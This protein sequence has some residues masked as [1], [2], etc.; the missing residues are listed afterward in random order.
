M[1]KKTTLL[2]S[3]TDPEMYQ[4]SKTRRNSF[5]VDKPAFVL[6]DPDFADPFSADWLTAI[7]AAE[8]MPSNETLDDQSIQLTEDVEKE[9]EK[10][11]KKFQDSKYFI[12]KTFPDRPSRWDEFGYDNY[13][14][15]RKVQLRMIQFMKTFYSTA[16]KFKVDL[17]AN[18]Y[19]QVRIDEIKTIGDGLDVKNQAQEDFMIALNDQTK[20]RYDANNK[21]WEIMVRVCTAGKRI[22]I[23]NYAR[24]QHY[25][26]PPG[27]ENPQVLSISGT[28]TD[29]ANG[30]PLEGV[31]VNIASLGI[32]ATTD[33]SG[34]Y[35]FGGLP[36]GIYALEFSVASYVTKTVNATVAGGVAVVVNVQ[37]V[38]V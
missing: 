20:S 18:G 16:M 30:N 9:M 37:M 33:I 12:E 28:V 4:E 21:A 2:Y 29:S 23:D 32:D 17:I 11:R 26:L 14:Q 15:A 34:K 5:I 7:Q 13:E 6:F 1:A 35:N 8:A 3:I 27:E 31:L 25:L 19:T 22:F 38:H 24:Y 36:D 10:C